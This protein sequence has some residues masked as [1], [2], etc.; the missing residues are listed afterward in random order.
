MSLS[1]MAA[2][3]VGVDVTEWPSERRAR[4]GRE[5]WGAPYAYGML[6]F[7][8]MDEATRH[9]ARDLAGHI[10]AAYQNRS[11]P[12]ATVRSLEEQLRMAEASGSEVAPEQTMVLAFACVEALKQRPTADFW[13]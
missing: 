2:G 7:S 12:R 8:R 13:E 1:I 11:E 10:A 5:M 9:R 4:E 6:D 3:T